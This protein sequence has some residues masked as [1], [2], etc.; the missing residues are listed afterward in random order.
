MKEETLFDLVSEVIQEANV[1]A[2]L[3]GGFAVNYHGVMRQT[4]DV[5]FLMAEQDY[6]K[7]RSLFEK[8]A[9]REVIRIPF[10]LK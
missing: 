10:R 5:D 3:I 6:N 1:S 9:C 8:V 2:I 4:Q 7:V